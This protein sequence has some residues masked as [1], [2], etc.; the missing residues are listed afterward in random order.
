MQKILDEVSK[1]LP[2]ASEYGKVADLL[3]Q[4]AQANAAGRQAKA[5]RNRSPPPRKNWR[6]SCSR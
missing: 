2:E 3:K 5:R 6:T 4:G 1:A